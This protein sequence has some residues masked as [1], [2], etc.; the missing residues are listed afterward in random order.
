MHLFSILDLDEL[1]QE[2]WSAALLAPALNGTH[3]QISLFSSQL[4][5][6]FRLTAFMPI[7]H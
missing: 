2:F 4:A 3:A 7:Y 1:F 6:D 5:A